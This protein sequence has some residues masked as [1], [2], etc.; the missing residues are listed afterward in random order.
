M[1]SRQSDVLAK[2]D[3]ISASRLYARSK[4]GLLPSTTARL[5]SR[6]CC[7]V[8]RCACQALMK[9]KKVKKSIQT[10]VQRHYT[11][12][13]EHN[14]SYAREKIFPELPHSLRRCATKE[15]AGR[16]Q[17]TGP[18]HHLFVAAK[19]R[20]Q[21]DGTQGR[22]DR[23]AHHLFVAA[24][25]IAMRRPMMRHLV[26][27]AAAQGPGAVAEHPAREHGVDERPGDGLRV[28]RGDPGAETVLLSEYFFTWIFLQRGTV[29]SSSPVSLAGHCFWRSKARLFLAVLL[30]H[31]LTASSR[32]H[33]VR[34]HHVLLQ[35][36]LHAANTDY[37]QAR[38]P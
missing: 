35:H 34:P 12:L 10:R 23:V 30:S 3:Y 21:R 24:K 33:H 2:M 15:M 20:D 38:R 13:K 31:R 7:V 37:P 27:A 18:R 36:H 28:R 14:V 29:S 16:V 17:K 22:E 11:H 25:G 4:Y 8:L 26:G 9:R 6:L 5:T 1:R 32:L 19:V